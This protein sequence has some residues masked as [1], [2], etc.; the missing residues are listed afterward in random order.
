MQR[1]ASVT[2]DSEFECLLLLSP[3]LPLHVPL[4]QVSQHERCRV[5]ITVSAAPG[6][7]PQ[8]G[9]K[10]S[11]SGLLVTHFPVRLQS[12]RMAAAEELLG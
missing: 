3:A 4:A 11:L 7:V 9:H 2:G 6:E 8:Q 5:R 12:K 10:V 1:Q